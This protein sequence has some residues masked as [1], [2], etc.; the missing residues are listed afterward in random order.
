MVGL[1]GG[2]AAM[3]IRLANQKDARRIA[4]VQVKSW[5]QSYKRLVSQS[6]LNRLSVNERAERW[7]EFL[8]SGTIVYVLELNGEITG[9][10]SG[11]PIRSHHPYDREIY[12]FYLLKEV[13]QKGFGTQMILKMAQTFI[14]E[15]KNSMIV[16]VLKDNPAKQAYLKLGALKIDEEAILIGKQELTEECY[17]WENLTGLLP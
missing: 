16:W 13:Q 5:Q 11:G 2:E 3:F 17:V 1:T 4:E 10:I 12:A 14:T 6:Y 15:G 8:S 7:Q 9:F